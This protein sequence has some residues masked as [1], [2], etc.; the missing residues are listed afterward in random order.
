ME[1]DVYALKRMITRRN[2]TLEGLASYIGIDRST[3]YRKLRGGGGSLT[4]EEA[5]R[6]AEYLGLSPEET[7]H[8]FLKPGFDSRR[9]RARRTYTMLSPH[10]NLN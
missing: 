10:E 5:N 7:V 4:V 1:I 6:A 3:L 8:I 9:K 2:T